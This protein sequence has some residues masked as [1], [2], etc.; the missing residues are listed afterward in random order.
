MK[1]VFLLLLSA[2]FSFNLYSQ[3]AVADAFV[4]GA[5]KGTWIEQA[6]YWGQQVAQTAQSV[7]Y[8]YQQTVNMVEAE[9]RAISNIRSIADVESFDD[10]MKWQNRQLY[11]E[12]EVEERFESLGV[13][14]GGKTYKAGQIDEIPGA[15][16]SSFG[17]E[18]W[19]DFSEDQRRE[20]Y[21]TLGLSPGNY[22]Y[23]KKWQQREDDFVRKIQVQSA[24]LADENQQA[25]ERYNRLINKYSQPADGL[26]TNQILKNIHITQMQT[27]MAL[28][29]LARQ[30]SEK[31]EY[32]VAKDKLSA[33]PPSPPRLSDTFNANPFGTITEYSWNY[34][35]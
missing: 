35:D 1:K 5:I 8:L 3:M 16:G 7:E 20:M 9:K 12:R 33:T 17:K 30:I 24:I 31:N 4:L 34:E 26:D 10:F 6:A 19:N 18:Y 13:R 32:D 25:A 15:M 23:V 2:V 21:T 11:M 27:E 28:R 29:D 14:I 22:N